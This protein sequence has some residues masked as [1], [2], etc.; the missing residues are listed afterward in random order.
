MAAG[1]IPLDLAPRGRLYRSLM[2]AG[3]LIGEVASRTGISRK[4]LRLYE[5]RGILP[6]PRRTPS[7]YRL[8]APEAIGILHFVT[9]ARR[10]GLTLA[11]IRT[12]VARRCSRPGPCV[13]V[14]ALLQRKLADLDAVQRE[15]RRILD[16][17]DTANRARGVVCRHIEEGGDL[18]WTASRSARCATSVRK[19]SST[20]TSS[21]SARTPT[22]SSSRRRNGTSWSR[23]SRPAASAGSR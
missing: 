8:Y 22:P 13:H 5:A 6:R 9:R 10:L 19:S 21:A 14:R 1:V 12:I 16:S 7:G 18:A 11:E 20:G 2:D 4:A 23:P 17:W 15:L 3:L